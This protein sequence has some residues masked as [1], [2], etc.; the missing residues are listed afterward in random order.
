MEEKT[1][2]EVKKIL[3]EINEMGFEIVSILK[4]NNKS[5]ENKANIG[6]ISANELFANTKVFSY[7]LFESFWKLSK[8]IVENIENPLIQPWLRVY[9]EKS[10]DIFLYFEKS[11]SEREQ[12]VYK[13]WLCAIGFSKE[14]NRTLNYDFFM[15]L[16]KDSTQKQKFLDLKTKGFPSKEFNKTWHELFSAITEDNLPKCIEKYFLNMHD[17]LLTKEQISNF[18]GD[19]SLYH[20][21]NILTINS[22]EIEKMDKS[23]LYRCFA[24][25]VLCARSLIYFFTKEIIKMPEKDFTN[26]FIK[27]INNLTNELHRL[28]IPNDTE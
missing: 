28:R 1:I 14:E 3:T 24:L 10:C 5:I 2:Y 13:Y 4:E 8:Q 18:W 20:H 21:P 12:V 25:M 17:K 9:I 23:H 19:M 11:E 16:L 6:L 7:L 15:N 22:I 27:K 26:E